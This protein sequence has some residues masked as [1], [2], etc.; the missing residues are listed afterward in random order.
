MLEFWGLSHI[1]VGAD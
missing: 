1:F